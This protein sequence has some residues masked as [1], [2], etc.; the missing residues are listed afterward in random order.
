MLVVTDGGPGQLCH[1]YT[2]QR[3]PCKTQPLCRWSRMWRA[4]ASAQSCVHHEDRDSFLFTQ[5]CSTHRWTALDFSQRGHSVH[6]GGGTVRQ[7]MKMYVPLPLRNMWV[8][9]NEQHLSLAAKPHPWLANGEKCY[10][11]AGIVAHRAGTCL[12]LAQGLDTRPFP[13]SRV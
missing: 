10:T 13:S 7:L 5:R 3:C 2:I 12:M 11:C 1:S 9:C 4:L 8:P 6:V